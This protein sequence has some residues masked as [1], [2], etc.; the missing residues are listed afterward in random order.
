MKCCKTCK[1]W[2]RDQAKDTAGRIR[3]N[4]VAP[5][6]YPMPKLP[7]SFDRYY[8]KELRW[9]AANYGKECETHAGL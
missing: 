9:M 2:D 8:K 6:L 1:Y 4:R 5:C 7:A 3:S